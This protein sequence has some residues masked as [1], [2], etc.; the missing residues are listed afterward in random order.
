M[1]QCESI[2]DPDQKR[3]LRVTAVNR[4]L[5]SRKYFTNCCAC[6]YYTFLKCYYLPA[7]QPTICY[8]VLSASLVIRSK[9]KYFLPLILQKT[10]VNPYYLKNSRNILGG[11]SKELDLSLA[12]FKCTT[13]LFMEI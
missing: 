3:S 7:I 11:R 8:L 10:T 9:K 5:I 4:R 12:I 13:I 2:A 1:K 6:P